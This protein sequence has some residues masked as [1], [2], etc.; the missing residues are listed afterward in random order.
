MG[1]GPIG[2]GGFLKSVWA[3]FA[4]LMSFSVADT[5]QPA[6]SPGYEH[7]YNL[8]FP[9]AIEYFRAEV[10]REPQNPEV[11]NHLAQAVLYQEMFRGGALESELVSGSNP[12]LRREKLATTPEALKTFDDCI[13]KALSLAQA[14]IS[15]N[16]NDERAHYALGVTYALRANYNFLVRKAWMDALK[17]A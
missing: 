11:Y 1:S 8:E 13:Y 3:A 14:R 12:F 4:A 16:D 7:F 15:A 2:S 17:D 5:G 10:T 9:Q 6:F